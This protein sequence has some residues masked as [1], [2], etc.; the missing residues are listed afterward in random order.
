METM[1]VDFDNLRIQ[2]A[3]MYNKIYIWAKGEDNMNLNAIRRLLD[4]YRIYVGML[5]LCQSDVENIKSLEDI[6]LLGGKQ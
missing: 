2:I 6:K 1:K 4:T 5:L 3:E